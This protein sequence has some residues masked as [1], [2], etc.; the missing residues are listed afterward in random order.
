[1]RLDRACDDDVVRKP[2][3]RIVGVALRK[4]ELPFHGLDTPYDAEVLRLPPASKARCRSRAAVK[5]SED[6]VIRTQMRRSNDHTK[7]RHV[8]AVDIG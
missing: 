1:L 2:D 4:L 7:V 3:T 6:E 5:V 8:I